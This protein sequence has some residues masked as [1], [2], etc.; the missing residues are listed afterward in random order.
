LDTFGRDWYDLLDDKAWEELYVE[1]LKNSG[2]DTETV[3]KLFSETGLVDPEALFKGA[4]KD[5]KGFE[6]WVKENMANDG[7][8]AQWIQQTLPEDDINRIMGNA[9]KEAGE[10]FAKGMTG[11]RLP[12]LVKRTGSNPDSVGFSWSIQEYA[13][14]GQPVT[15]ELFVAREA[16]PELVGSIGHKS[17]VMNNDQIVAGVANGVADGQAEQNELLRQQNAYLRIIAAKS[18][19]VTLTPSSELGRV[20]KRSEEMRLRAEGV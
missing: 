5:V 15:G 13:E 19:K 17:T 12:T 8:M 1:M 2:F 14:G 3:N 10:S 6:E 9:G 18:G 11:A 7:G 20:N 16:G 4:L